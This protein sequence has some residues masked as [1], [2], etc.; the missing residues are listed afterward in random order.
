MVEYTPELRLI[1]QVVDTQDNL[2]GSSI[3]SYVL[4]SNDLKQNRAT[5]QYACHAPMASVPTD[6]FDQMVTAAPFC[7]DPVSLRYYRWLIDGPFRAFSDKIT[8]EV[9]PDS[10]DHYFKMVKLDQWPANIL[11][12][13]CIA[14]RF[15]IEF[16][17]C[18]KRWGIYLDAGID[19]SVGFLVAAFGGNKPI[20][21]DPWKFRPFEPNFEGNTNHFWFDVTSNW[22]RMI[23]GDFDMD[24]VSKQSFKEHPISCRPT[25]PI[26]G[27]TSQVDQRKLL[28]QS[29]RDICAELGMP[30]EPPVISKLKPRKVSNLEELL[31]NAVPEPGQP[32]GQLAINPIPNQPGPIAPWPVWQQ[33]PG[34]PQD[35]VMDIQPMPFHD[36]ED[37]VM[38][39]HDDFDDDFFEDADDAEFEEEDDAEIE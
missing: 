9:F 15:P 12:N 7:S 18:V 26:W 27:H 6:S 20:D 31:G 8:L 1:K 30:T 35:D 13:F 21:K 32:L 5:L 11:Y 4:F 37:D 22:S 39:H 19:P 3:S 29:V 17:E 2:R 38:H 16:K 10:K 36:H 24:A 34:Q 25:N 23:N 28:K 33:Q 14:S